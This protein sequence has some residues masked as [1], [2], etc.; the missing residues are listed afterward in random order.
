MLSSYAFD[1]NQLQHVG[2]LNDGNVCG[3]LSII[4]CFH[5]IGL[6]H[7]FIDVQLSI[8]ESGLPDYPF[9]IIR[10]ILEALPSRAAFSIQLFIESWNRSGLQPSIQSDYSDLHSTIEALFRH[11]RLKQYPSYPVLS[12]FLASFRCSACNTDYTRVTNWAGQLSIAVP[13]LQLPEDDRNASIPVLLS[14]YLQQN[15]T[16]RCSNQECLN[17][18]YD[19]SYEAEPGLYTILS[20]NRIDITNPTR[21]KTNKLELMSNTNGTRSALLGELVSCIS[22]RGSHNRGHF[23]SYHRVGNNWFL[24]DDSDECSIS[25]NPLLQSGYPGETVDLLFFKNN[26]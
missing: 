3:L 23:V 7:H 6:K 21:K 20:V 15:I 22:H 16:T 10:K 8:S 1:V 9:L 2:L 11:L 13:I 17:H 4:L 18:I 5:R 19:G 26:L 24:N 14:S 12:K 25:A